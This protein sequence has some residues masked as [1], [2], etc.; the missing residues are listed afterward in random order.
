MKLFR[1]EQTITKSSRDKN[2]GVYIMK[3]A[4]H[5]WGNPR[6]TGFIADVGFFA[7]EQFVVRK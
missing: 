2:R 6:S 1:R 4:G 5:K 7:V 3:G